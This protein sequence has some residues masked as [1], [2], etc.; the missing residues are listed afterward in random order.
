MNEELCHRN[1]AFSLYQAD[2]MPMIKMGE[3]EAISLDG[4]IYRVFVDITN[5]KVAPTVMAKAA[6][7]NVVRPD[8]LT[9]E[10]KNV[11]VISASW[12]ANKEIY[13]VKPDLT[14][15]IDQK[16]LKRI[17]IRNGHPG[18]TTKTIMYIVKGSGEVTI[19]YDSVKGGKAGKTVSLK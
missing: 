18:K 7:N 4:G 19:T 6:Q 10:G 14:Q 8:L 16:D 9:L 13:K 15:L 2:E 5:P 11:E 12:V 1:M 17:I 3:A